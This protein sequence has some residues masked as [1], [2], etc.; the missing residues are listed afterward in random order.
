MKA[1][2]PVKRLVAFVEFSGERET[3]RELSTLIEDY[4]QGLR[5]SEE[6]QQGGPHG[7]HG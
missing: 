4:L 5:L 6:F 1:T 2:K 3:T 7:R